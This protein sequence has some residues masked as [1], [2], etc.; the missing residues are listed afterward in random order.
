MTFHNNGDKGGGVS[1]NDTAF[2][3]QIRKLKTP[4]EHRK[5]EAC[6]ENKVY[7][8]F[9]FLIDSKI[10][11]RVEARKRKKFPPH[12]ENDVKNE[13]SISSILL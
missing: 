11:V 6:P 2:P 10:T 13:E 7:S 5:L 1:L 9:I 3:E 12:E 4:P 8:S